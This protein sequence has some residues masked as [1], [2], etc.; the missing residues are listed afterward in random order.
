MQSEKK[1]TLKPM[2]PGKTVF[3]NLHT[4]E[5]FLL[6]S[7]ETMYEFPCIVFFRPSRTGNGLSWWD[8]KSSE[9]F[10]VF[11]P[12]PD[13]HPEDYAELLKFLKECAEINP[14]LCDGIPQAR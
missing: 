11:D 7:V 4:K 9:H 14:R 6:F 1:I 2:Q 5:K 13:K 10:K 8:Q 3:I 12:E